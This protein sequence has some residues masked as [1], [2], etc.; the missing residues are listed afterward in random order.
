[1]YKLKKVKFEEGSVTIN[2]FYF[3]EDMKIDCQ[4]SFNYP[5]FLKE[6]YKRFFDYFK[7]NNKEC[8]IRL[9]E[10]EITYPEKE[11][12]KENTSK[13]VIE[14]SFFVE[15]KDKVQITTFPIMYHLDKYGSPKHSDD[16]WFIFQLLLE[17]VYSLIGSFYCEAIKQGEHLCRQEKN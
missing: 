12:K 5:D 17:D 4:I 7:K 9:K 11:L 2:Y 1:M 16:F 6:S 14:T 10:I 8:L 15:N 13:I 3:V